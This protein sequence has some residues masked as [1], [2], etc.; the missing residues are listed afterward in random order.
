MKVI[1]LGKRPD[2]AYNMYIRRVR[3]LKWLDV[4]KEKRIA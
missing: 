3:K 2:K 1:H 4:K